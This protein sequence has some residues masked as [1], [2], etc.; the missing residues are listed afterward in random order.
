MSLRVCHCRG[1]VKVKRQ[2]RLD[3][4]AEALIIVFIFSKNIKS[5]FYLAAE[6]YLNLFVV[7]TSDTKMYSSSYEKS[8]FE[9][10]S[11]S[12]INI[13]FRLCVGFLMLT[14]SDLHNYRRRLFLPTRLIESY[15]VVFEESNPLL[16]FATGVSSYKPT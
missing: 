15:S 8:L 7:Q 16:G 14:L 3:K 1:S 10:Y 9:F 4:L 2:M 12:R 13:I 5:D 6:G 11:L